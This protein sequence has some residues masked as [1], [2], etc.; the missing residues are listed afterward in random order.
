MVKTESIVPYYAQVKEDL[1]DRIHRGELPAGSRI[2][3]EKELTQYYGVSTITVRRATL[4]LVEEKVLERKQGKGTFVIQRSFQRSFQTTSKGFSEICEANGM[5]ASNKLLEGKI[6]SDVPENI[7]DR[8]ELEKGSQA[9]YIKRLRFAD[10]LPVVIETTYFP[11]HYAYLLEIDLNTDFMYRTM[12]AREADFRPF[13]PPGQRQISL[14]SADRETAKLLNVKPGSTL[15]Y[16][17]ANVWDESTGK[18]LH[19]SAHIGY[20]QKYNFTLQI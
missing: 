14:V 11:I 9:V 3:S 6:V 2:P 12:R 10:G 5:R 16:S 4:E 8:L 1:L 13:C 19:T 20:A 15:L 18:P 7:L 17:D